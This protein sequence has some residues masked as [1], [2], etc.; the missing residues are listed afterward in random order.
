MAPGPTLFHPDDPAPVALGE[1]G[2]DAIG[3]AFE[4]GARRV[5]AAGFR[6][7]EIHTAHGYLLH[8]FLSPYGNQRDDQDGGSL[9]NRIIITGG[10]GDLVLPRREPLREPYWAWKRSMRSKRSRIGRFTT[11]ML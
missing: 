8:Q 1:T 4:T 11:D 3:D 7:L 2:I 9:E 6:A 5:F 10:D